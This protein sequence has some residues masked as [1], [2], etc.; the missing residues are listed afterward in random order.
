MGT[1]G[2]V[3]H[4]IV[5]GLSGEP[6]VPIQTNLMAVRRLNFLTGE[7]L[8]MGWRPMAPF[9]VPSRPNPPTE[10]LMPGAAGGTEFFSVTDEE[11]S[12]DGN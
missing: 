11:P 6:I 9:R 8:S 7:R 3:F 1:D 4:V 12:A 5:S 10:S 2:S